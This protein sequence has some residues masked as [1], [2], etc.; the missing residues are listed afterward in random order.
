VTLNAAREGISPGHSAEAGTVGLPPTER[1]QSGASPLPG[2]QG[3]GTKEIRML[4]PLAT[5][6]PC[7]T[8][9]VW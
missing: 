8:L 2:I 6:R 9:W 4:P 3:A 1:P 7:T 5:A